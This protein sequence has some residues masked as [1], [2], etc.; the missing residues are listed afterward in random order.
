MKL[1]ILL[2]S[3]ALMLTDGCTKISMEEAIEELIQKAQTQEQYKTDVLR[4]DKDYQEVYR[5]CKEEIENFSFIGEIPLPNTYLTESSLD[6]D[7]KE[8]EVVYYYQTRLE[9]VFSDFYLHLQGITEDNENDITE[10]KM[11]YYESRNYK[12]YRKLVDQIKERLS[13]D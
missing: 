5:I 4:V 9:G 3:S 7:K 1:K 13:V 10:V 2:I 6:S 8:G 11:Y 12:K